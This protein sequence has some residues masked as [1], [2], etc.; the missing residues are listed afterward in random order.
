MKEIGEGDVSYLMESAKFSCLNHLCEYCKYQCPP[1]PSLHLHPCSTQSSV[2][3]TGNIVQTPSTREVV[4][5]GS[6]SEC[7]AYVRSRSH[8]QLFSV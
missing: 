5:K 4:F 3:Q 8:C 7:G 6:G 1:P 2:L